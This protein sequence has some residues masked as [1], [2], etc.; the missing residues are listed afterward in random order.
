[1][2][3]IQELGAWRRSR[4]IG[5]RRFDTSAGWV[6][7]TPARDV[8]RSH[9]SVSTFN[10]WFDRFF[11]SLRYQAIADLLAADAPD[12]MVF[13]EVTDAALEVFLAQRWIREDYVSASAVGG[14]VGSY[15]MLLLSRV[16]LS[17]V[18]YTGLPSGARRGVLRADLL[19]NGARTVVCSVHLD[20]GKRS[21]PLRER[22]FG[23]VFRALDADSDAV[24]LGDFNMRDR[25]NHLIEAPFLDVWPALRPGEDGYTEDTSING[26]RYD[27]TGKH[28]HVR[29]DRVLVKGHRWRPEDIKLL[30]TE[31]ISPEHPRVFPSDHFGVRCVLAARPPA[32][33]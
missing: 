32:D 6:A 16:P 18:T 28:R 4:R 25:E 26:M 24:A 23:R 30:G 11:A 5:V 3:W 10:I 7:A 15:G 33:S 20:S 8:P 27:S 21:A 31:P 1:M 29:F 13:Q 12:V 9:L 22:Q 14:G 19:V 17:A 2:R